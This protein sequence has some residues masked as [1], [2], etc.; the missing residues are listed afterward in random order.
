MELTKYKINLTKDH[1][2]ELSDVSGDDLEKGIIV[3][4]VKTDGSGEVLDI[5]VANTSDMAPVVA[6]DDTTADTSSM[7]QTEDEI[8]NVNPEEQA[9]MDAVKQEIVDGENALESRGFK[10]KNTISSF[11]EFLKS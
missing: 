1:M 2:E 6:A 5:L 11:D 4:A 3:K 9:A 8:G 10:S 7:E